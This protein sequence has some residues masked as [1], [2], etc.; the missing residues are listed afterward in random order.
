MI[1]VICGGFA[2]Y[3]HWLFPGVKTENQV[4]I[5]GII[6]LLRTAV[7]YSVNTGLL[8]NQ[9]RAGII[10]GVDVLIY[11]V[12]ICAVIQH[13][14]LAVYK[15]AVRITRAISFEGVDLKRR[16][17]EPAPDKDNIIEISL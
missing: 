15:I 3:F 8:L 12:D 13:K 2:F 5:V 11:I 14:Y 6:G 1:L 9:P 7:N 16:V 4:F 10:A 17:A